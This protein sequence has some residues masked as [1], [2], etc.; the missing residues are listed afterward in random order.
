MASIA[1]L[2]NWY[3]QRK[4][5]VSYSMANRYGVKTYDAS[6]SLYYAL[7]VSSFFPNDKMGNVN[8]LF[9]DLTE[10]GFSTTEETPKRGD[11]F[12]WGEEGSADGK[13]GHCGVFLDATRVISCNYIYNGITENNYNSLLNSYQNPPAAIYR[14]S[15]ADDE[16]ETLL[17]NIGELELLGIKEGKVIAEGWHYSAD[18]P[19]Q[20]IEFVNAV[21]GNVIQRIRTEILPREDIAEQYPDIAGI[22]NSGFSTSLSVPNDTAVFIRGI[23]TD[24]VATDTLVFPKIIIYEQAF[25]VEEENQFL[26]FPDFFFEIYDGNTVIKRGDKILNQ[27]Y[28]NNEL[29][30]IPTTEILLPIDYNIY[31]Q[32]RKEVKLYIN[33][34]VFHGI[35]TEV[36]EDKMTETLTV[37]LMHVIGEWEFRDVS[38]NLACKNRTINDIYSTLDFRYVGWN[39][40][41]L[42]DSA[43]R[44]IDYVYSRQNK[45]EG[46]TKTCEL[47]D[48]LYWRVGFQF[49]RRVEIGTFGESLPYLLTTKKSTARNIRIIDEPIITHEFEQVFNILTVYG[50]KSDSGMSSMS[51]REIYEEE[52]A[53][54]QNFPVVILKNGINNERNY[55]YIEFS[56]LAPNTDIEYTVLDVESIANESGIVIEHSR[57]MNDLAPFN[58]DGEAITDEDRAICANTAYQSA[59]KLLKRSR[60]R[61]IVQFRTEQ[62]PPDINVGDKIRLI[63]DNNMLVTEKCSK[64][65]KEILSLNEEF[66][67]TGIDYEFDRQGNEVN[68]VR[69]ETFLT[70]DRE[71]IPS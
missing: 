57:A 45:L 50:E 61:Y 63:Y 69:L 21:T 2:I 39:I 29:M 33:H 53:Q 9:T 10:N 19:I 27:L 22:I 3:Q 35:T 59:I 38:T 37:S 28:W 1:T 48:D 44:N 51:L 4:G 68:T 60:R 31:F 26:Q 5:K 30:Y 67:I 41:Y 52:D 66:Y 16:D 54:D 15:S 6:S 24:G 13:A 8:D 62:L 70:T 34:K 58:I 65:L 49:G 11:I 32:G 56:K 12:L 20:Y 46:L 55:D 36:Q 42:Q 25:D 14:N 18:K 7:R 64:Y 23:R 71:V 47:T 43:N 17:T 40:N